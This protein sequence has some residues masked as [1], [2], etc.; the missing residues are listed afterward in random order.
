[1]YKTLRNKV[2]SKIRKDN[3]DFNNNRVKEAKNESE[4]WK[5]AKEVSNPKKV[6]EWTIEIDGKDEKDELIIAEAFNSYF[7][8]KI[9]KL[10]DGIDQSLVTDPLEKFI[11]LIHNS[12]AKEF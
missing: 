10:K 5:I 6:S 4:L 7:I 8:E 2:T 11:L 1:M 9:T 3:V 12:F